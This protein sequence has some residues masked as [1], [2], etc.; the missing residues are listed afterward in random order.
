MINRLIKIINIIFFEIIVIK[1]NSFL[2]KLIIIFEIVT[3]EIFVDSSLSNITSI[4]INPFNKITFI[5]NF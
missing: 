5:F 4:F 2:S 1:V 3:A